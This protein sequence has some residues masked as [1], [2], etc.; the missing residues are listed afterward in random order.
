[1]VVPVV[2]VIPYQVGVFAA[3][4]VRCDVPMRAPPSMFVLQLFSAGGHPSMSSSLD[5]KSPYWR[6]VRKGTAPAFNPNNLR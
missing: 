4:L 3:Q 6:L 5:S 1:M 2:D